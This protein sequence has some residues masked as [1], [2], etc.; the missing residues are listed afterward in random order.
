MKIKIAL[1]DLNNLKIER[2]EEINLK[3][4]IPTV[5]NKLI[6]NNKGVDLVGFKFKVKDETKFIRYIFSLL[7]PN[8]IVTNTERGMEVGHPDY[9]LDKDERK[10]FIEVKINN[11]SLRESQ[12]IWLC[13]NDNIEYKIL[14]ISFNNEV[15][16][17]ETL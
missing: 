5:D 1:Y 14:W 17:F 11:D 7:Y 9:I 13:K 15:G 10:I 16:R 6:F 12:L 8:F 4:L 2:E 3:E